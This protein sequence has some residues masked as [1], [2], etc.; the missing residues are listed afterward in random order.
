MTLSECPF[1]R[2]IYLVVFLLFVV[3]GSLFLPYRSKNGSPIFSA[4]CS[5]LT[6]VRTAAQFSQLAV[7]SLPKQERQPRSLTFNMY[8]CGSN[9]SLP[10]RVHDLGVPHD[11]TIAVV[12]MGSF[13]C[14][15]VP[16]RHIRTQDAAA[17]KPQADKVTW[18]EICDMFVVA[19]NY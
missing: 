18:G 16:P 1:R 8:I 10:S 19:T 6:E 15:V 3:C 14:L 17:S 7:P 13:S 2:D 4:R 11:S 12:K 9:H 5:F